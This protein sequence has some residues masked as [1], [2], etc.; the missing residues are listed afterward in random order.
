M[1]RGRDTH[2]QRQ[3]LDWDRV[4]WSVGVEEPPDKGVS[5]ERES[6]LVRGLIAGLLNSEHFWD[7]LEKVRNRVISPEDVAKE[8]VVDDPEAR[9]AIAHLFKVAADM[10]PASDEDLDRYKRRLE[11]W[12]GNV[13]AIATRASEPASS[14][15]DRVRGEPVELFIRRSEQRCLSCGNPTRRRSALNHG[16]R[17]PP[18]LDHCGACEESGEATARGASQRKAINELL[19]EVAPVLRGRAPDRVVQRYERRP[20]RTSVD[21]PRPLPPRAFSSVWDVVG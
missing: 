13:G 17:R 11:G 9:Q 14:D 3:F 1:S 8:Y 15:L 21:I 12:L 16:S 6:Q 18:S 4:R 2:T 5:A 7:R 20:R 10:P 19:I